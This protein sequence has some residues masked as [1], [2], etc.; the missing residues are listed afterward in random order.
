[1]PA[2]LKDNLL[3]MRF[4]DLILGAVLICASLLWLVLPTG[5]AGGGVPAA[6]V[7]HSGR[8]VATLPLDRP[9]ARSFAF[10]AG[11]ITVEV[12][13]GKGAHISDSNCPEKI[14]MHEGWVGGAGETIVCLP[15]KLVVQIEGAKKEYD[16]V[17][18]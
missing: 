17:T 8:V 14:C 4:Q 12:V 11:R 2:E 7:Y 1:M 13:P 18:Y 6:V 3:K 15:N 16:A 5:A 9:A 10:E